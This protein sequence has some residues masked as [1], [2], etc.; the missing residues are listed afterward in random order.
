MSRRSA[1]IKTVIVL[2]AMVLPGAVAARMIDRAAV[3]DSL[4]S[5][6]PSLITP[7]DS[8][9]VYNN[10]FDLYTAREGV[11]IGD[12]IFNLSWRAHDAESALDIVRNMAS[13]A[14]S[15][16]T[17]SLDRLREMALRWPA[18]E[19]RTETLTFINMMTNQRNARKASPEEKRETIRRFI[20]DLNSRTPRNLY[21]RIETLHGLCRYVSAYSNHDMLD[22]YM[23]SL[24]ML[25]SQLPEGAFAIRNTFYTN[26][27]IN[28]VNTNPQKVIEAGRET[29]RNVRHLEE[30][31]RANGRPFRSYDKVL[32][33]VSEFM[34][35]YHRHMTDDEVE[36][37]H[38]MMLQC[39][40]NE[41]STVR[42]YNGV[43]QPEIMYA[44][45]K[46]DY[47]RARRLIL[48]I[49]QARHIATNYAPAALET[50]TALGDKENYARFARMYISA[51]E[52]KVADQ[53]SGASEDLEIA[54]NLYYRKGLLNE[55]TITK[56]LHIK[57]LEHDILIIAAAVLL[58]MAIVTLVIWRMYRANRDLAISLSQANLRLTAESQNLMASKEELTRAR[59]RA[60]RSNNLQA[61]FIKN[62]SREVNRPLEAIIENSR[63]IADS[64]EDM[65]GRHL[66]R[67]ADTLHLNT[68]LLATVVGDVL[69]LS[70]IDSQE[71]PLHCQVVDLRDIV[72]S[73]VA[74][75]R[76][77]LRPGVSMTV[78]PGCGS[79]DLYTDP[80]RVQQILNN[81]LTNAAKFTH[82]GTITVEYHQNS[83]RTEAQV[84]V[85]DTGIGINPENKERIFDRFVKL[86]A[87]SQG[88]GL[89][90][91]IARLIA[92]R[93]GGH[94]WLDTSQPHRTGAR[95]V[96][97]IPKKQ[98]IP[99][100]HA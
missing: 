4:R 66:T 34:M 26:M 11:A 99:Q 95:F 93:L 1:L 77:R 28:F 5:T 8:L 30:Y 100:N 35:L 56:T 43:P 10:L 90:L 41:P 36:E 63:L 83:A 9:L 78:A 94:L 15:D 67:F 55:D 20:A 76:H 74:S 51:L 23:D 42:Q 38:S 82:S 49:E 52:R 92:E 59:K 2:M 73:S 40:E 29:I 13:R 85:T 65:G 64:A 19:V 75:T 68:E 39:V 12:T 96:L 14:L 46:G 53:N 84:S 72:E 47:T 21:E 17:I 88:A 81:L 86:D 45:H 62:M 7:T 22:T 60:E 91:S 18:S 31:Y 50:F 37:I 16:T 70:D 27:M 87:Q 32:Y 54:Y 97:V 98:A 25:I 71:M 33:S 89:G 6:L 69:R 44:I 24:Q 3:A 58:V 61:D 79:V 80:A 48:T 57:A